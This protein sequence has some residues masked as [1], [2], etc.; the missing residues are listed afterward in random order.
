MADI[1]A[2][3]FLLSMEQVDWLSLI[4]LVVSI[5]CGVVAIW[6]LDSVGLRWAVS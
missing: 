1:I 5:P 4:Y 2:Q 3:R 6:V